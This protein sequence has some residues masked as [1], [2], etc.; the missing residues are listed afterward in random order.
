MKKIRINFE[1]LTNGEF[2]RARS[3]PILMLAEIYFA[4]VILAMAGIYKRG[5]KLQQDQDLTV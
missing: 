3:F 5:V 4:L 1:K 2:T